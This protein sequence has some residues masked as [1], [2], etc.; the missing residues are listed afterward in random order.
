[1]GTQTPWTQGILSQFVSFLTPLI[2]IAILIFCVVEG[3]KIFRGQEG[4]SVKKLVSGLLVLVFIVGVMFATDSIGTWG[5]PL[6]DLFTTAVNKGGNSVMTIIGG[7][8]GAAA[9]P[10]G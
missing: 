4:A 8:G 6:S 5:R 3:F 7:G 9:A 1:M 10:G 2:G